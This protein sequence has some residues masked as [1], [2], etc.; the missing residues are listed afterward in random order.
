[1]HVII[2]NFICDGIQIVHERTSL[3]VLISRYFKQERHN[4]SV[5]LSTKNQRR[6]LA[7]ILGVEKYH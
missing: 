2:S 3:Q 6:L 7:Y 1:M 5:K 4:M